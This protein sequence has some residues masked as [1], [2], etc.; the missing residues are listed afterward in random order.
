MTASLYI[1]VPFC[2]GAC[3][4]CDFYSIPLK[5]GDKRL[6]RFID[7]LIED[8]RGQIGTFGLTRIPT[9]Y[10]GGGTPSLLGAPR[11]GRLLSALA[12]LLPNAP[13][14]FTLELN[15]E[16]A[17]EALLEACRAGGVSRLSVGIQSF[18]GPSRRGVGRLGEGGPESLRLIGDIFGKDFSADLISGLPFQDRE[19]LLR[20][21]ETLLA[22]HPGHVSLYALSLEA[23]TPLEKAVR[24]GRVS[25]P[26]GE[27][28]DALWLA[29]R[30]ALEQG[31]YPQYEVSNFSLPGKASRHNIRYWLMENWL[32]AGPAASGTL[33]D[34]GEGTGRRYT[35]PADAASYLG[36]A[37]SPPRPPPLREE[38]LDRL[39]LMKETL[40]M[41][42]RYM[43]GP[44]EGLFRKRFH[45]GLAEAIPRT[46]G[47]W[48]ERDLVRRDKTALTRE[49]LLFLNPFL[50]DCFRELEGNR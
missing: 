9:V 14:E 2:A 41:G 15:P 13:E 32:G 22:Y 35:M 29:G 4:Y 47:R 39:T 42:F 8:I 18:Y 40:L 45:Q 31:G 3:D 33:I 36:E 26:R 10:I 44:D 34:E 43:E 1:H 50:V 49:G 20:D 38:F 19:I 7:V 21:I 12:S 37:G 25:L 17:G 23:G 46:L 6:D 27:E 30:D 5:D 28:A 24:E 48:Q 11:L 16:S